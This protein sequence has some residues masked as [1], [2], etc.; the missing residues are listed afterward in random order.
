MSRSRVR[1][2]SRAPQKSRSGR[3]LGWRWV[4]QDLPR[5]QFGH[6]VFSMTIAGHNACALNHRRAWESLSGRRIF[7]W[8]CRV[9]KPAGWPR[10]H[11]LEPR[12]S[13]SAT[14]SQP[15]RQRTQR[16]L[17]PGRS[18]RYRTI[19]QGP[20]QLVCGQRSRQQLEP[21]LDLRNRRRRSMPPR[22]P[23]RLP[24]TGAYVRAAL[25]R[26]ERAL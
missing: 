15:R 3:C 26:R 25:R 17:A 12:G 24:Y 10:R 1:F 4:G 20:D 14:T 2:P 23:R 13:G 18:P 8:V 21:A 7:D 16:R 6:I 19:L 11:P 9:A 5:A 22:P